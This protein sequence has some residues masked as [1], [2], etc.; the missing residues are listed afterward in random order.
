MSCN[1]CIPVH[2]FKYFKLHSLLRKTATFWNHQHHHYLERLMC[3]YYL[4][5]VHLGCRFGVFQSCLEHQQV[6]HTRDKIFQVFANQ[7]E[8]QEPHLPFSLLFEFSVYF[9]L[10]LTGWIFSVLQHFSEAEQGLK[11][12]IQL[13]SGMGYSVTHHGTCSF[14]FKKELFAVLLSISQE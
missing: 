7:L 5:M 11:E 2:I 4:A 10:Y 12:L 8:L 1:R 3:W 9:L 13:V 14:H 6:F